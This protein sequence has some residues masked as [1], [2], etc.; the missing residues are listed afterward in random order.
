MHIAVAKYS[1]KLCHISG[2][3]LVRTNFVNHSQILS[4][5]NEQVS[6]HTTEDTLP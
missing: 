3:Y 2:I 5:G 6:G 4:L 1:L